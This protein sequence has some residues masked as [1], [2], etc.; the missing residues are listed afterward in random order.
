MDR[1]KKEVITRLQSHEL[2][3]C[4]QGRFELLIELIDLLVH[5]GGVGARGLIDEVE[6]TR[7]TVDIRGHGV[8]LRADLYRR[9][10][11]QIQYVSALRRT[12]YDILKFLDALE[13]SLVLHRVLIRVL[14]LLAEGTGGGHE[15][16]R[17]DG[18]GYIARLEAIL[19]HLIR[20]HPYAQRV[21]VS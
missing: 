6:H 12:K 14:G 2:Q 5:Q 17:R 18:I 4:R 8:A 11:L 1:G 15:T 10:I 3:A 19:R 13:R 9:Y 20:L 7:H 21:R 16:L